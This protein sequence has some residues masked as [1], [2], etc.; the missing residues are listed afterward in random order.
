MGAAG[1]AAFALCGGA[2]G[3]TYDLKKQWRAG[4][5]PNGAWTMVE[6]SAALPRDKDWTAISNADAAYNPPS[7]HL[8]QPAFAP[9]NAP[10]H[11]LPAWFKAA[12]TPSDAS[13]GWRKGDIVMHTTDA[14]N[15]IGSGLGALVFTSPAAGMAT[16]SG[17]LYNARNMHRPQAWSLAVDGVTVAAGSLPGDGTWTRANKATFDI[18]DYPLQAGSAVVLTVFENAG[19]QGA[20]DFVGLDMTVTLP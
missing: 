15:G 8:R 4:A 3:A 2:L 19:A 13:Y 12:V 5:N 9:G 1:L 18:A 11:Y 17:Y 14:F 20:G 16:L 6:G 7:G 10:G